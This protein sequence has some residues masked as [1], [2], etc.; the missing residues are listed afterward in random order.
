MSLLQLKTFKLG[1][2]QL[3]LIFLLPHIIFSQQDYTLANVAAIQ[4]QSASDIQTMQATVET[5]TEFGGK[6]QDLSYDYTMQQETNGTKVMVTTLGTFNIQIMADTS[7]MSVSY[8]MTDGSVK[9]FTLTPDEFKQLQQMANAGGYL[10]SGIKKM[11]AMAGGGIKNMTD[12]AYGS[13]LD[14]DEIETNENII[15]VNRKNSNNDFAEVEFINKNAPT[16][17]DKWEKSLDRIKN[18]EPKNKE[19]QRIKEKALKEFSD[20]KEKSMKTLTARRVQKINMKEGYVE[21]HWWVGVKP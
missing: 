11:Y 10:D 21:E 14:T 8:L 19:A 16:M 5:H 20:R 15:R 18:S 4:D 7:D 17:R 6:S 2:Y 1:V 9:K 12:A 3:F 13:K